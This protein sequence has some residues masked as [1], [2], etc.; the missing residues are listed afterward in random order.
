MVRRP[1]GRHAVQG[2]EPPQKEGL[3]INEAVLEV[4][5]LTR[6]EEWANRVLVQA[7]KSVATEVTSDNL[8]RLPGAC[9]L[10]LLFGVWSRRRSA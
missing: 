9:G 10:R 4:M 3:E 5:A 7:F 8:N 6:G 1:H 2:R